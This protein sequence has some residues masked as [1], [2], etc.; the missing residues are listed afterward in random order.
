MADVLAGVALTGSTFLATYA[1]HSTVLLG[2]AWLL[3]RC[4]WLDDP[5]TAD[6]VWKA[7]ALGG[8]VSALWLTAAPGSTGPG[9][10]PL[11]PANWIAEV[12]EDHAVLAL[13]DGSEAAL[14]PGP[15]AGPGRAFRVRV[16]RRIEAGEALRAGGL[17][18]GEP[19]PGPL[20]WRGALVAFWLVGAAVLGVRETGRWRAAAALRR[21][22]APPPAEVARALDALKDGAPRRARGARVV[23]TA[24][25]SPCAMGRGVIALP[26]RCEGG[27]APEELKAV[28][29]HELAHVLRRDPAWRAVLRGVG[30]V[31]WFQPLNRLAAARVADAA[32]LSCD[33]WAVGVTGQPMGLARSIVRVA[34]WSLPG[35]QV[36]GGGVAMAA[37]DGRTLSHR[38]RRIL[39]GSP[40]G[41]GNRWRG[42]ALA[43]LV[44]GLGPLLPAVARPAPRL[45]IVVTERIIDD[46]SEA[47]HLERRVSILGPTPD[48]PRVG[49]RP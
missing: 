38:V 13:H 47:I 2:A 10:T 14:A 4:G 9:T 23:S 36:A 41:R 42:L 29:A 26:P 15:G 40:G 1:L 16:E 21:T 17:T 44:V 7:A 25:D 49:A 22:G 34:E 18:G 3:A 27:L 8:V 45:A 6:L 46:G 30:A 39:G 31:L 33:D 24:V 37:G 35:R 12:E 20:P 43:G 11:D 5:R 19:G 48:R 28:L 32:E